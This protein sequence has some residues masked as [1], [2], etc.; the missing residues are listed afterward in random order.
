[1]TSPILVPG[2]TGTQG[3]LVVPVK[4]VARTPEGYY[5]VCD[6]TKADSYP[7]RTFREWLRICR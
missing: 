3:R 5:L 2:G 4:H 7:V 1:M 6:P